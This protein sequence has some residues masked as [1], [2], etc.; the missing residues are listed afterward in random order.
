MHKITL[1]ID[2]GQI[3]FSIIKATIDS[4]TLSD[5]YRYTNRIGYDG[6]ITSTVGDGFIR[7]ITN[8]SGETTFTIN[9]KGILVDRAN[10]LIAL[11]STTYNIN[12]FEDFVIEL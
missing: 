12:N 8:Q 11:S 2:V 1:Y 6:Y 4:I 9:V 10:D 3:D 5:F 7:G